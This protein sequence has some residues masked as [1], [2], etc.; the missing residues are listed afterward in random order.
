M[1]KQSLP[2][3]SG[4]GAGLAGVHR[5]P[6]GLGGLGQR[7]GNAGSPGG[8]LQKQKHSGEKGVQDTVG[9]VAGWRGAGRGRGHPIPEGKAEARSQPT[10]NAMLTASD[11]MPQERG[12]SE[13][14]AGAP[15]P[16]VSPSVAL[17]LLFW[18]RKSAE[19]PQGP[20]CRG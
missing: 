9:N 8:K 10:L 7:E 18:E 20:T 11:L 4:G 3:I 16:P 13:L 2:A 1:R 19:K 12:A 5:A 14:R 17:A 6:W 15:S